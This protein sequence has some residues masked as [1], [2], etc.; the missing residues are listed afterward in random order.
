VT[1]IN[2]VNGL[3]FDFEWSRDNSPLDLI[4]PQ[5]ITIVATSTSIYGTQNTP[6]SVTDSF[7]L[8][9]LTACGNSDLVT[10]SSSTQ[11]NPPSDSYSGIERV[12]T[13]N[14]FG[15]APDYCEFTITCVDAS[16]ANTLPCQELDVNG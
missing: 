6:E 7:T 13:Y 1:T 5:E 12:F 8:T 15:I 14:E 10:I 11:T 16:P 4:T 2:D 9:P 3:D